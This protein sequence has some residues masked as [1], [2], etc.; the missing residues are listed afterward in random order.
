[1]AIQV[2][3]DSAADW[4]SNDPTASAGQP[5]HETDTDRL[6]VGDG[7]TAYTD[8]QHFGT[9]APLVS[10]SAA[11]TTTLDD[12][13]AVIFHPVA[14]TNNRTFTIDSNANVPYRLGT[15]ITFINEVNTLTIAITSD[16]LVDT[17]GATG[18]R[19]LAADG[20][21]TAVKV[22]STRWRISGIG[23]T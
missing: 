4:I 20:I 6:K 12:A 15:V 2:R 9:N 17:A 23:L 5:C 10:K 21:A 16:T 22:G 14:D 8:L 19:T 11:Y 1:M 13:G 18:S 3:R 7:A